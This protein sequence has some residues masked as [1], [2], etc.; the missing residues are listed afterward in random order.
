MCKL[1]Y[2]IF[3]DRIVGFVSSYYV[4]LEGQ[5]DALVFAGGI[6][7]KSSR[8]R[9]DVVKACHCLGFEVDEAKNSDPA[10]ASVTDVGT[11]SAKHRT[12]ICQTDEQV[13]I[14]Q[15]KSTSVLD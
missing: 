11:D 6:G 15:E 9:A 13:G 8:L 7:E 14:E 2:D 1:A 3:L 4:K 10:D 12:L 5:V